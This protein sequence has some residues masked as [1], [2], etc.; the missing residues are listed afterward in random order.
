MSDTDILCSK[1]KTQLRRE[2]EIQRAGPQ[3]L[4][5]PI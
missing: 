1:K 3:S 2:R 4:K 5:L